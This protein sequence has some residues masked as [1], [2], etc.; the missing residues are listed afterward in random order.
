[1]G[2]V[3]KLVLS[4]HGDSDWYGRFCPAAG[5]A[6][7]LIARYLYNHPQRGSYTLG[8]G[9]RTTDKGEALRKALEFDETVLVVQVDAGQYGQVE[10]AVKGAKVVISAVGPYWTCG[11]GIAK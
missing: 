4:I 7:R 9:V 11:E 5:F 8:V 3:C 6:G 10:A 2:S 1:M